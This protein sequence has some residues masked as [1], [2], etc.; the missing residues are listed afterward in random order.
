MLSAEAV[1]TLTTILPQDRTPQSEESG[2]VFCCAFLLSRGNDQPSAGFLFLR[3]VRIAPAVAVIRPP[4]ARKSIVPIPQ[5]CSLSY[6][7]LAY[8]KLC[9]Y[10]YSG[11]QSISP[12]FQ[13]TTP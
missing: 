11:A 9:L 5:V 3:I 12:S 2:L 13:V 4:N 7:T 8:S 1:F 10:M 6:T